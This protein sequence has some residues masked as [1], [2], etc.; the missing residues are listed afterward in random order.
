M[1]FS[2]TPMGF[3][4][5]VNFKTAVDVKKLSCSIPKCPNMA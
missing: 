3:N 2:T 4:S 1:I 5:P